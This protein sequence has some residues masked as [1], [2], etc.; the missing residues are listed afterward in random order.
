MFFENIKD[1]SEIR[2]PSGIY[3]ITKPITITGSHIRI[4]GED[5]AVLSGTMPLTDRIWSD[6]GDRKSVV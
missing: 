2:I 5:G 1:G 3:H 6:K 4:T